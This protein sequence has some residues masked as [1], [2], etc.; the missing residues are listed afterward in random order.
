[1]TETVLISPEIFSLGDFAFRFKSRDQRL[2]DDARKLYSSTR[3]DG[4]YQLFDLDAVES[5]VIQSQYASIFHSLVTS[6][7]R[8]HNGHLYVDGCALVTENSELVLLAGASRA[9]KT[10]LT[11]AAV[12]KLGWKIVAE[13][14]I[15]IAPSLDRIVSVVHPLSLRAGAQQLIAEATGLPCLTLYLDRWLAPH[16]MFHT[17]P[18]R[19]PKFVHAILIGSDCENS[20]FRTAR[21]G[22][23]EFLRAL[24]PLSNALSLDNGASLLGSCIE[25]S[26]SSIISGGTVR[27][28]LTFLAE[29]NTYD[30]VE[31][32]M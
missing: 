7:Y 21:V 5:R 1:M 27:D 28:R 26:H 24:L 14:L 16:G 8:H 30:S 19:P 11:V 31:K 25:R 12:Q 20:T 23:N 32:A 6:A 4:D 10:T 3:S 18:C 9:G 13:D 15:L 17:D 2:L 29:L 22:S